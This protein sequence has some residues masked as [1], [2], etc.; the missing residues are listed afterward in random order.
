MHE[1]EERLGAP[2]TLTWTGNGKLEKYGV[3]L[4]YSMIENCMRYRHSKDDSAQ[5]PVARLQGQ[6]RPSA[7]MSGWSNM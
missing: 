3:I 6:R 2:N 4:C 5:E 1:E 7:H